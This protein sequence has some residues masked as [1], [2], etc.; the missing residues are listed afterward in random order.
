MA[1]GNQ[2]RRVAAILG[3]GDHD[4]RYEIVRRPRTTPEIAVE[5]DVSV[6]IAAP[7]DATLVVMEADLRKRA[8]LVTTPQ[9]SVCRF[10][11]PT[12]EGWFVAG[13]AHL[14]LGGQDRLKVASH[15]QDSMNVTRGFIVVQTHRPT[16][17]EGTRDLVEAWHRDRAHIV[18]PDRIECCLGHFTDP[19][20]FRPDGM[21]PAK[22]ARC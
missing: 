14:C 6:V 2:S 7:Q 1:I 18:F 21:K 11:P 13:R 10:L 12:S 17:P 5:P 3:D 9:R 19:E 20:A 8:A 15:L 22:T 4:I 16:R